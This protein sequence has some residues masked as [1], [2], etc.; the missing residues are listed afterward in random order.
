MMD[1]AGGEHLPNYCK[2]TDFDKKDN[3]ILYQLTFLRQTLA[4]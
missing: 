2:S 4:L 3:N 1:D